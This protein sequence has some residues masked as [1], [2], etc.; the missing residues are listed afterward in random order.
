MSLIKKIQMILSLN[1]RD[2]SILL[3]Q[4]SDHELNTAE[5]IALRMHVLICRHCR[6]FKKQLSILNKLFSR[7]SST[8]FCDSQCMGC[9][10]D[11]KKEEIKEKLSDL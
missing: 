11:E 6:M 1:C 5:K 7:F 2:A 4:A 9:L 10:S 8:D 3:T